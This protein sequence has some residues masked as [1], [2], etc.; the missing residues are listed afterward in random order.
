MKFLSHLSA[1]GTGIKVLLILVLVLAIVIALFD[2]NWFRRPL[3]R[4]VSG[5]SGREVRVA[6]LHVSIGLALAPT[7]RLRGVYIQNAPWAATSQP[8]AVAGEA[9]FT[10]SLRSVWEQRRVISRLVLL[11]ADVV[12]ERTADGLRNWR[13][14]VPDYRGPAIVKV[15]T[16]E[17]HRSRV[18]FINRGIDLDLTTAARPLEPGADAP[19]EG[20]QVSNR[21]TFT[22]SY[23]GAR[24][25]G[26]ALT[27][28]VLSFRESGF[29]FPLRGH[30][31][32]GTTRLEIEGHLA[33]MFDLSAMDAKV[34]LAGP[35]L[36]R[37][38]PFLSGLPAASRPYD[39]EARVTQSGDEFAF[40]RLR[41][42]IGSSKITGDASY[43]RATDRPR[44]R[45]ALQSDEADIRD[46]APL[47]GVSHWLD[48]A[49]AGT[50]SERS[51]ASDRLKAVDAHV[52]INA[53]RLTASGMP[54]L[55]S[56]RLTASLDDGLLQLNPVEVGMAGGHVEGSLTLNARHQPPSADATMTAR[57]I[58]LEKL[59][60]SLAANT[61]ITGPIKARMK[62]AGRG[63]SIAAILGNSTG[64]AAAFV[65]GGSISNLADAKM[66]LNSVKTLGLLFRG[67]RE[68]ALNCGAIAFAFHDGRGKSQTIL[69]DTEQ[70]HTEGTGTVDLRRQQ[71][72]LVLTPRPK[73][74][75]L[76]AL[77]KSIRVHGSFQHP[78]IALVDRVSVE[79]IKAESSALPA[80]ARTGADNRA[81]G[82]C[83]PVIVGLNLDH[84]N[85]K[86]GNR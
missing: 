58:R 75:A 79:E 71:F 40:S 47:A 44:V 85:A 12:M 41:G 6:D 51:I 27:G 50:F 21:I 76:F 37:L 60:P 8:M 72:E 61:R 32:S 53:K 3:E 31:A 57:N 10:F 45:A 38:H 86:P 64:S 20:E 82:G 14:L 46:L 42:K 16:L 28:P 65:N 22:G 59:F 48:G 43:N 18:R 55:E 62:L 29:S 67:D 15:L 5:K 1:L 56:L 69:L 7:V 68:I 17:A 30:M 25:S 63:A 35:D 11:D 66:G 70:T 19:V 9:R 23:R 52:T 2:W 4:Y 33:D 84:Q 77:R 73:K 81:D 13:L 24:F 83:A 26:E 39:A 49:A 78:E 80:P 34:R 36:A 74:P 54:A